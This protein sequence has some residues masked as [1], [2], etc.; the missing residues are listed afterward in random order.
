MILLLLSFLRCV[1][2]WLVRDVMAADGDYF[3]SG[4]LD[5]SRR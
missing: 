2:E 3:L 5:Q 1:I 4:V